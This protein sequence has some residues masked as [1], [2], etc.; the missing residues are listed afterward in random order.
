MILGLATPFLT[1]SVVDIGIKGSNIDFVVL[2]LIA[3]LILVLTSMS[4]GLI[5]SWV[6]IHMTTRINISLISDFWSKLLRLPAKFYDIKVTGDIM[7]RFGDHSRIQDFLL[8]STI[9]IAFSAVNFV[10]LYG[11]SC[12]LQFQV[13]NHFFCRAA[14]VC[15]MDSLFP[16]TVEKI[17]LPEIRNFCEE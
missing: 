11:Y 15:F 13:F 14:L 4:V 12:L 17:R 8:Q 3:Q 9:K 7:Q 6:S 1:Q 10:I 16:E 5:N 2:I